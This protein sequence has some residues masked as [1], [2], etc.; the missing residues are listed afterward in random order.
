MVQFR[1]Y[2][3]AADVGRELF[4]RLDGLMRLVRQAIDSCTQVKRQPFGGGIRHDNIV[5][6]Q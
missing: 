3:V 5:V 4:Q 2:S 6:K 1:R